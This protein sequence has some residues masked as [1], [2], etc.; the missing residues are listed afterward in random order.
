MLSFGEFLH[1]DTRRAIKQREAREAMEAGVVNFKPAALM[2]RIVTEEDFN[3]W[4]AFRENPP[5]SL[6]DALERTR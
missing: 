6:K 3:T 2:E 4:K 5:K 1:S